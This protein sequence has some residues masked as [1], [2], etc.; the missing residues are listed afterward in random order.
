VIAGRSPL[1]HA[2]GPFLRAALLLLLGTQAL[3]HLR[4]LIAPDHHAGATLGEH[5]HGGLHLA[6][7]GPAITLGLA[8]VLAWLVVRAAGAPHG[9]S[10]RAVKVVRI[11]PLAFVALLGSYGAQELLEGVFGNG[12][13]GDVAVLVADGGWVAL[14]LAIAIGGVI[15]LVVRVAR[16]AERLVI[17]PVLR[18]TLT[19]E[20]RT[21]VVRVSPRSLRRPAFSLDGAGRGPPVVV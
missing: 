11:W 2:V 18:L 4:Y 7:T 6:A 9:R 10:P 3:H 16:A 8:L 15:A 20:P 12:H 5:G 14:P 19:L 1:S 13:E 17:A 21:S